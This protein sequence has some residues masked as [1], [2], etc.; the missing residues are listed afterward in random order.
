MEIS[1]GGR[2]HFHGYIVFKDI[3][4]FFLH[5]VERLQNNFTYEIDEINDL[6]K[7]HYYTIKQSHMWPKKQLKIVIDEKVHDK[8]HMVSEK[9]VKKEIVGDNNGYI[10]G[11]LQDDFNDEE[12]L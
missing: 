9:K 8:L 1:K 7:W 5:N 2:L 3:L 11:S 12:E 10:Q 4:S 6:G